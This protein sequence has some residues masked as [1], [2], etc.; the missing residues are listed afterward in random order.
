MSSN[1]E[2][3]IPQE[4]IALPTAQYVNKSNQLISSFYKT[5]VL[6]N[7]LLAIAITKLDEN[8]S[9]TL[10]PSELQYLFGRD[11][12]NI[13]KKI[14]K[15]TNVL[16]QSYVT[17]ESKTGEGGSRTKPKMTAFNITPEIEYSDGTLHIQFGKRMMPYI[18]NLTGDYTQLELATLVSFQ[19][20]ST[21][22]LYELLKKDAYKLKKF[23]KKYVSVRYELNELRLIL[24]LIESKP[25][26]RDA[27][28][29]GASWSDLDEIIKPEDMQYSSTYD[30]KKKVIDPARQEMTEKSD[31]TFEYNYEKGAHGKILAVEFLITQNDLSENVKKDIK[32]R[33]H[34][35][36]EISEGYGEREED[37]DELDIIDE[38][39]TRF[40]DEYQ[41]VRDYLR[42]M[43][44]ST[45]SLNSFTPEYFEKL[46]DAAGGDMDLIYR[47]IDY[48][49]EQ[50]RIRNFFKWLYAAVR[51]NYETN[52]ASEVSMEYGSEEEAE[53]SDHLNDMQNNVSDE[54]KQAVWNM[55]KNKDT[56]PDFLAHLGMD[57][58][59]M[60]MVM[61]I[62]ECI[63]AYTT[64][65]ARKNR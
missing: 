31:I 57:L 14:K 65:I 64:Y 37:I 11:D 28:Q 55:F 60:E 18:T 4:D 43:G 20:N 40:L 15:V 46:F 50:K 27:L 3:A 9:A 22:R 8:G 49:K 21:F 39:N 35:F 13:Y 29:R 12:T 56:F 7:K 5:S 1:T 62:D 51:D 32:A 47:Q 42:E 26:I 61:T 10:N 30:L 24:G 34:R 16:M 44:L 19:K 17:I 54:T 48:A 41:N 63:K 38:S 25:Y 59:T 36:R 52:A 23:K 33:S 2:L 6:G 45:R 58:E 53:R